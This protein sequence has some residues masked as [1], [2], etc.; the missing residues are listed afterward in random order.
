MVDE[1]FADLAPELSLA[2]EAA[3]PGLIVLRSFGKF[4]GLAGLRLG[5]ALAAPDLAACLRAALGP[6]PVS[7]PAA[8]VGAHA[9]QDGAWIAATRAALGARAAALDEILAAAGLEIAGG[10]DL[11][12]LVAPDDAAA[13]FE[14]LGRRGILVRDFP[15]APRW[16]RFGLPGSAA[17]F[18]RL[19]RALTNGRR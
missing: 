10:T 17:A 15:E 18:L 1:A 12:R 14:R 3:R 2:P 11:F 7:G 5:F 9:L 13:L 4:F 16:L 8:Y 19:R 6:W